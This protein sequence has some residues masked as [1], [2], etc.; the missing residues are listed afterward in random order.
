[1][2]TGSALYHC[3]TMSRFGEGPMYVCPDAYAELNVA[4]ASALKIAEGDQVT[5]T[6]ATGAVQVAAKVGKRVPQGVVFSPYHFGEGSVNTIT[7]GAEVTYVTVA[8][9]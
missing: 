5:V 1:M 8:K 9:K 7:D 6:S 2:V 4:D 3:G